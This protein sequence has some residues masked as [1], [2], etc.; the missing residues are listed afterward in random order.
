MQNSED[1]HEFLSKFDLQIVILIKIKKK[2]RILK[3]MKK[4]RGNIL[5]VWGKNQLRIEISRKL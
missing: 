5:R 3:E 4:P 2:L 1:F